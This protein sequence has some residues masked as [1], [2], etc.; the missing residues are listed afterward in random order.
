MQGPENGISPI[1]MRRGLATSPGPDSSRNQ[2]SL[3]PRISGPKISVP[4]TVLQS[5]DNEMKGVCVCIG[6]RCLSVDSVVKYPIQEGYPRPRVIGKNQGRRRVSW[7]PEAGVSTTSSPQQTYCVPVELTGLHTT[8]CLLYK[9]ALSP[10]LYCVTSCNSH[11]I[12]E[13]MTHHPKMV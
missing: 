11:H 12:P 2:G 4:E 7:R 10:V 8:V 6:W 1:P 9:L 5:N 3:C 13:S